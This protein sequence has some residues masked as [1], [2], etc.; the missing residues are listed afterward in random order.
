MR[1][2]EGKACFLQNLDIPTKL[3]HAGQAWRA[4]ALC[5]QH[6][7]PLSARDPQL[8][9]GRA[10]APPPRSLCKQRG[11]LARTHLPAAT[12]D[13]PDL[14]QAGQLVASNSLQTF[15]LNLLESRVLNV[16]PKAQPRGCR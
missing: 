14:D 13:L 8:Y 3:W 1:K 16:L 15:R 11:V 12:C 2:G 9:G 4:G 7:Q 5:A 6:L 10:V